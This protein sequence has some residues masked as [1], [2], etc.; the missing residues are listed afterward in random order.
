MWKGEK[1]QRSNERL[2]EVLNSLKASSN[3]LRLE[4]EPGEDVYCS[5]SEDSTKNEKRY[6]SQ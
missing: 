3:I 5:S 4:L 2:V 6:I 1:I